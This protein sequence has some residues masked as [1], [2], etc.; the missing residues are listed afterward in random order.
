MYNIFCCLDV[1]YSQE[2]KEHSATAGCI[3]KTF[4]CPQMNTR[5][6]ERQLNEAQVTIADQRRNLM[7]LQLNSENLSQSLLKERQE[8]D[9]VA[10][11]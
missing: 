9:L 3:I 8:R 2:R 1:I 7:E 10:A 4:P 6:L 11:K 5:Q